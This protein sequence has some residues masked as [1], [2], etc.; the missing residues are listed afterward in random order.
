MWKEGGIMEKERIKTITI[1][2]SLIIFLFYC[3]IIGYILFQVVN[4]DE[5]KNFVCGIIFEGIGILM[6]LISVIFGILK[7]VKIGFLLPA[8]V[9][10]AIYTI[11]LNS[12][13]F[14]AYAIMTS[15]VFFL[16]HMVVLFFYLLII[17]PMLVMGKK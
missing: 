11:I 5:H 8:I 13:N 16:A 3:V 6:L 12:L 17:V 14:F 1:L 9:C 15:N 2:L 10:T 7:R 4:L